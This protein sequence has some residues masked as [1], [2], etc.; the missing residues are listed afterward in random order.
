[1][2]VEV[3]RGSIEDAPRSGSGDGSG[4]GYGDGSGSGSGSGYGDGY[5]YGDGDGSGS[6]YGSGSG[7]GYGY[8][9]GSGSG[10]GSGYGYGSGYGDGDGSGS[11][12]GSGSGSGYG[13][14]SGSGSGSGYG[15]GY[16]DGDGSGSG[17]G[18]WLSIALSAGGS[19]A[20]ELTA[21][22]ARIALWRSSADGRACNGGIHSKPVAV[23]TREKIAGP[24]KICTRNGLHATLKPEA[25]KGG[26]LWV[27][28]LFGEV[29]ERDDKLAALEREIIAEVPG[30]WS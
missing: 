16:G 30:N 20:K 26:K 8:G 3:L 14:G 12:Y 23:G 19:R 21:A 18:Y 4:S 9:S 15:D 27:V 29:Q 24:L 6:G 17:S 2:G 22:G 28:A 11:G 25:Y 10:S 7:S 13:Y 1:M 5:G